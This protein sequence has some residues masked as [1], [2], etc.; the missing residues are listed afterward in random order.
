MNAISTMAPAA[1]DSIVYIARVDSPLGTL[2][3]ASLAAGV[4]ATVFDD[5]ADAL[6]PRLRR[7]F[8]PFFRMERGDPLGVERPLGA[9]FAGRIDALRD[10]ALATAATPMQR[11]VWALVAAVRPGTVTTYA[12][13]A[14]RIGM[15]RGQR[16]VGVCLATNPVPLLVPCHRVISASGGLASHPGGV[17]RKRWLLRHEGA[18]DVADLA[19]ARASG[20]RTARRH[21]PLDPR[22]TVELIELPLVVGY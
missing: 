18:L 11:R 4:C 22:D 10:V 13:L 12:A 7:M 5:H 6:E 16:A 17:V 3:V 9:Y 14:E 2:H 8:G 15:P 19:L 20:T 21:S 1:F